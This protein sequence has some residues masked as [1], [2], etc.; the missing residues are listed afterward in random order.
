MPKNENDITI[1]RTSQSCAK[2][3]IFALWVVLSVSALVVKLE[4]TRKPVKPST[5]HS[6]HPQTS[7]TTNKPSINQPN[8]PQITHKL[9]K[10]PTKQSNSKQITH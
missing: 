8:H 5:I 10:L 9:A 3:K 6:N 7:E 1:D 2:S 4:T